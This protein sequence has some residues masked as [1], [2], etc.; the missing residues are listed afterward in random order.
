M[1]TAKRLAVTGVDDRPVF[2]GASPR[3]GTTLLR[4]MLNAHPDLAIPLETRFL[5][6]AFQRR[7]KWG[8]LRVE[9]NRQKFI[10]RLVTN[11]GTRFHKFGFDPAEAARRMHEAPGHTIGSIAA[12]PFVMYAEET[13]AKRWG[14][15]RPA[16]IRGTGYIFSM[17][18]D[19]QFVHLVRDPRGSVASMLKL[20][21]FD[22][23]V[24]K[25]LELWMR[26]ID[27][28]EQARARLSS[29]QFYELR[30]EDLLADPES[31]I[32]ALATWL[33]LDPAGVDAMLDFH[34]DN[35]V[36]ASD[37]HW[38]VS[39]PVDPANATKWADSLTS[40][41]LALV[42]HVAGHELDRFGYDR[43]DQGPAS[44]ALLAEYQQ[45][46]QRLKIQRDTSRPIHDARVVA[47]ITTGQ[48]R[49]AKLLDAQNRARRSK[50]A[51]TR[52]ISS[53]RP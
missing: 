43:A 11:R 14:D 1:A 7:G 32:R 27:A 49:F 37:Y 15:K 18:P 28:A 47:R 17:F 38:K 26:S 22:G 8:D 16:Y 29:D 50:R 6:G 44:E 34:E 31:E 46:S 2:V 23:S 20:G 42:D 4:T 12:T 48:R 30:Y 52:R 53:L 40:D 13:G 33:Q 35:D 45:W 21:W 41:Q 25:G 9:A 3:S 24:P 51:V 19:A 36:P 10:D 39:Q 5:R